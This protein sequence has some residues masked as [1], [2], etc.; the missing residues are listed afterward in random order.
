MEC[1]CP[2]PAAI[3]TVLRV[4]CPENLGQIQRIVIQRAGSN[5]DANAGVPNPIAVLASWTPLIT[6]VGATK[7]IITPY[8]ESFVIPQPEAITRGGNDNTTIN[9]VEQVVGYGGI[10][11][12]ANLTSVP[13]SIIQQLADLMCEPDLVWYGIN[14]NGRIVCREMDPDAN[15]GDVYSG[16][17]IEP[18]TLGVPDP[19]NNGFA[20]FDEATIRFGMAAGWTLNRAIITPDFNAKTQ[21]LA[22]VA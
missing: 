17:P 6:A 1:V 16:I 8:L 4:T 14:Q 3:L 21:L 7:I 12:T 18:L 19:G 11:V 15:P 10:T 13:A 5:F 9:G 2:R 22:P 20:T